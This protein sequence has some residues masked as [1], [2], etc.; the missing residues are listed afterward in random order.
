M[1]VELKKDG[2]FYI[3]AETALEA[4]AVKG[5]HESQETPHCSACG[6]H[7]ISPAKVVFDLSVIGF[8]RSGDS[9]MN[10]EIDK[11]DNT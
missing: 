3:I 8:D 1:R 10:N 9:D 7:Q 4:F 11:V 6:H 2:Y 5:T